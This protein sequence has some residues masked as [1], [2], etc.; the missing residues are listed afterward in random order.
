[1]NSAIEDLVP[2][3][4]TLEFAFAQ[5]VSLLGAKFNW[6]PIYGPTTTGRSGVSEPGFEEGAW[7]REEGD[8]AP[9]VVEL[10]SDEEEAEMMDVDVNFMER[11]KAGGK[12]DM[13]T[14]KMIFQP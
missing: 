8:Y 2:K 4:S 13:K 1:M 9:V 12:M 6:D 10:E 14:G 11:M 7:D 5:L 3:S